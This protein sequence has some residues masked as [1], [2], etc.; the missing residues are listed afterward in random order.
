MSRVLH[1]AGVIVAIVLLGALLGCSDRSP[2]TVPTAARDADVARSVAALEAAVNTRDAERVCARYVDPARDCERVWSERLASLELPVTLAVRR[3]AYGCAGDA[4]ATLK[5]SG[6]HGIGSVTVAR[7]TGVRVVDVAFGSRRSSLVVPRYGD[8]AEFDDG[9][10]GDP[11]CDLAVRGVA[12][13]A[14][15][16]CG[17]ARGTSGG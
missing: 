7:G 10:A 16:E 1:A 6:T 3:V 15:G 12:E 11:N 13:D 17:G 4:R 14:L 5:S 8:C 2:Y 9:S